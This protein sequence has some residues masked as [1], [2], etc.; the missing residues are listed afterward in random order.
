M[1]P[2]EVFKRYDI[3][4]KYPE[5]INEKFAE[6]LGRALGSF[7]YRNYR[8]KIV[9][10][11]DNKESSKPLKKSLIKGLKK[12]G[13][14][15][16][17]AGLGPTDYAAYV[18][19]RENSVS[20]QVTSSHLPLEFNGFKFMYPEGNGF[21]N[22]DLN[23]VKDIF[24]QEQFETGEGTTRKSDSLD[25]YKEDLKKFAE[26]KGS[27][28]DKKI[29][30]D[31]LGGAT[32][33]ILSETLED[34]GAEVIDIAQNKEEKPYRDP[35]NPKP[36]KLEEMKEIVR[37]EEA[38][39]GLATDMDGD[40]V[41]V[42]QNGFLDGNEIFGILAQLSNGNVVASIDTSRALEEFLEEEDEQIHYTRVGDPFVMDK[43]LKEEVE[44]A[45]EPN[46]HYS[47]L[48]FVAYNSGTLAALILS[49]IDIEK[50]LDNIPEYYVER[51][52]IRTESKR[53]D[54]EKIEDILENKYGISSRKDGYKIDKDGFNALIRP[55]GSSPKIRIVTESKKGEIAEKQ[56]DN[57]AEIVQNP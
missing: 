48:E 54:M 20:V 36:E 27:S 26:S 14:E 45:G 40:R 37:K 13:L 53:S 5:E 24:R 11:R 31:S 6:R 22:P 39:L 19:N 42:Y 49:G 51:R 52:V 38:D 47:F 32:D 29:V 34:L 10:C 46:G 1:K 35:P 16:I 7:T 44:L 25:K 55:S 12:S 56:A 30:V 41:A 18:G 23:T 8:K 15:V 3:R 21:L 9:V 33:P 4:G 17:D 50:K 2:E 28:W 43:A 57:L